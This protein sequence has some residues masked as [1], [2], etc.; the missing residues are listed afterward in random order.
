MWTIL[1]QAA[2]GT[3]AVSLGTFTFLYAF[4]NTEMD[5]AYHCL[6]GYS[7]YVSCGMPDDRGFYSKGD[8]SADLSLSPPPAGSPCVGLVVCSSCR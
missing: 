7:Q 6:G 4:S 5:P 8:F 1:F 2:R 3:I